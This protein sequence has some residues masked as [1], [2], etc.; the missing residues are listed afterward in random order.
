MK[1][2]R[3]LSNNNSALSPI[4]GE[5][6]IVAI[7]VILGAIIASYAFGTTKSLQDNLLIGMSVD[8]INE[9]N[10][11]VTFMGG[12]DADKVLYLDVSVNGYYYNETTL[13]SLNPVNTFNGDGKNPIKVGKTVLMTDLAP[14]DPITANKDHVIIVAELIGGTQLVVLDTKV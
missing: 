4:I 2:H 13:W 14:N 3:K 12:Q 9:D 10:I 5:I 11:V 1:P 7:A 8:K 6:L